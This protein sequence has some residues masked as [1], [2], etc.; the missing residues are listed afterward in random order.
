M[1]LRSQT[2][3]LS[4]GVENAGR[5]PGRLGW[6]TYYA[7]Y[8]CPW[9]HLFTCLQ[10]KPSGSGDENACHPRRS[11]ARTNN[12]FMKTLSKRI[13][14][15]KCRH[16]MVD[17]G[18]GGQ[19][20]ESSTFWQSFLL[21]QCCIGEYACRFPLIAANFKGWSVFKK[22]THTSMLRNIVSG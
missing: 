16:E 9:H 21:H 18:P 6:I 14:S 13:F 8:A 1:A 15:S 4:S 17:N 11:K 5:G 10:I 7:N 12:E 19:S 22:N 3:K 2:Q 20:S